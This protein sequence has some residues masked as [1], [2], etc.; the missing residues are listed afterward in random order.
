MLYFAGHASQ[1]YRSLSQHVKNDINLF[2]RGVQGHFEDCNLG[3]INS[4]FQETG[5]MENLLGSVN[6]IQSKNWDFLGFIGQEWII[7]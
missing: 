6:E 1:F 4:R 7:C 5:T 2:K 3:L